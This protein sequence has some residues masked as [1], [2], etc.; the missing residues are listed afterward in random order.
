MSGATAMSEERD[1]GEVLLTDDNDLTVLVCDNCEESLTDTE[2][3]RCKT[4]DSQTDEV[5]L[6]LRAVRG[7]FA[8]EER[9]RDLRLQRI[10]AKGL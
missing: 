1:K 3:Y 9:T 2:I 4:C 10:P 5:I 6:V 8:Y 7:S